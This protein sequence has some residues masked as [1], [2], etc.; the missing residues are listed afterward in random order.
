VRESAEARREVETRTRLLVERV[1]DYAIF[2]LDP[3]GRVT[4]WNRGAQQITDWAENEVIGQH[5]SIFTLPPTN[6][7]SAA[8]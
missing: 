7:R 2:T 8:P 4:S 1:R 3:E 6:G 5:V